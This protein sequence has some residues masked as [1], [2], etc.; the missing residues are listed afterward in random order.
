VKI[1]SVPFSTIDWSRVEPVRYPGESGHAIWRTVQ[2]GD[3]RV[4]VVEYSAGYRADHWCERGHIIFVLE[5]DLV[6]ELKD[7][8]VHALEAGMG[9]HV[10]DGIA[11]HRSTSKSGARLFIVD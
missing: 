2:A 10:P 9:Y 11:P 1:E 3:I 4:R 5:G 8:S 7:G 6:T